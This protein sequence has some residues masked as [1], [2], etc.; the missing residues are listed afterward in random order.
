MINAALAPVSPPT[1]RRNPAVINAK[2]LRPH[3]KASRF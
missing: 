1:K 2:A 3:V